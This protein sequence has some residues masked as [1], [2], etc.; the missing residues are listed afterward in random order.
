MDFLLAKFCTF[1]DLDL[2]AQQLIELGS[3]DRAPTT[4]IVEDDEEEEEDDDE[5]PT[6]RDGTLLA[7]E[8]ARPL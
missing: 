7:S 3:D 4:I 6:N 1:Q 2:F 8:P 5:G